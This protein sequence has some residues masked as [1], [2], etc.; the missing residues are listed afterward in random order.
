MC[1]LLGRKDTYSQDPYILAEG[2]CLK[3]IPAVIGDLMQVYPVG[4]LSEHLVELV[5][6]IPPGK[7]TKQ[8]LQFITDIVHSDQFLNPDCRFM[9]LP[10]VTKNIEQH[11]PGS[12]E[13]C[14]FTFTLQF[15]EVL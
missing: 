11:L 1:K 2:G 14:V 5:C 12:D 6:T 4:R 7:L 15:Y 10:V 13:V 9:L 3:H 8:K